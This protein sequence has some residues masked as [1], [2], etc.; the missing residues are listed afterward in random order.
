MEI[1][2]IVR[3]LLRHLIVTSRFTVYK[4]LTINTRYP[5]YSAGF[6]ILLLH[7]GR[8]LLHHRNHLRSGE[9]EWP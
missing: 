6:S 4:L 3:L 5:L 9:K 2:L 7:V 1:T 8:R